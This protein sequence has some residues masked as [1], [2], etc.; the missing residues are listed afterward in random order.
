MKKK[1]VKAPEPKPEVTQHGTPILRRFHLFIMMALV[2]YGNGVSG[3]S[4]K[5]DGTVFQR[6]TYGNVARGWTKPVDPQTDK[7]MAVRASFSSQSQVWRTLTTAQRNGWI[8]L[9]ATITFVNRL[10]ENIFLTGQAMFNKLNQNLISGGQTQI[11]DAPTYTVPSTP[12]AVT[13]AIAAG[14]GTATVTF[15]PTPVPASAV[16]QIWMTAPVSAGKRFLSNE[17]KLIANVAAAGTSPQNVA[18]AYTL[19]Y[20]SFTGKAASKVG[21]RIRYINILTGVAS[22]FQQ[23]SVIIAA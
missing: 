1:I 11:T 3:I 9:A 8:A 13:G 10:G 12:T 7:Q 4:G 23:N 17:Y 19:V 20:G 14:A 22:A 5:I 16:M 18:A 21:I 6:G 2:K 15:V